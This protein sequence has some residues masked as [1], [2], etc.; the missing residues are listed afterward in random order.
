MGDM[1]F[2]AFSH[3]RLFGFLWALIVLGHNPRGAHPPRSAHCPWK[4]SNSRMSTGYSPIDI[5]EASPGA[6]LQ[7]LRRAHLRISTRRLRDLPE[8]LTIKNLW[9]AHL[10]AHSPRGTCPRVN[11]LMR[12]LDPTGGLPRMWDQPVS[13]ILG[14]RTG[15]SMMKNLSKRQIDPHPLC[16]WREGHLK[17]DIVSKISVSL[18]PLPFNTSAISR[19]PTVSV[20]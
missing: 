6:H 8:A 13:P 12:E 15:I 1:H 18:V 10:V 17:T 2:S 3:P 4:R 11:V 20:R 14:D 7:D 16:N 9:D 5:L 19:C